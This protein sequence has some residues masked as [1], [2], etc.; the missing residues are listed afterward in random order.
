M[1]AE[2]VREHVI[3]IFMAGLETPAMAMTWTWYLLSQH[4]AEEAKLHAE[5]EAVLGGRVPNSEDL[6]KLTYTRMV[7]DESMRLYPPVHTIAREALAEDTL[8]GKARPQG[9]AVRCGPG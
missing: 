6:D 2:E 1:T 4:A 3:T 8:A 9:H 7:I 5:L